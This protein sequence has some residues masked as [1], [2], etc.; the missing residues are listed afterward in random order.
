MTFIGSFLKAFCKPVEATCDRHPVDGWILRI[1]LPVF[2]TVR[3]S[4]REAAS[5]KGNERGFLRELVA[6]IDSATKAGTRQY[7]DG[8]EIARLR[9]RIRVLEDERSE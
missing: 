9:A 5:S 4:E 6:R 2:V 1:P 3:V 7:E 8:A